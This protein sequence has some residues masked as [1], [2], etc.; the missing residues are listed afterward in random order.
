MMS[1]FWH[2][3][4][5]KQ[6]LLH[7]YLRDKTTIKNIFFKYFVLLSTSKI[8]FRKGAFPKISIINIHNLFISIFRLSSSN[9]GKNLFVLPPQIIDFVP[10]PRAQDLGYLV[11]DA[12]R[13]PRTRASSCAKCAAAFPL[14]ALAP[15]FFI[16][17]LIKI[18]SPPSGRR[19][20]N[21]AAPGHAPLLHIHYS[22]QSSKNSRCE[23]NTMHRNRV[24]TGTRQQD[25]SPFRS[26]P[27][28]ASSTT[29]HRP[30]RP[31]PSLFLSPLRGRR[32]L[33]NDVAASAVRL[34]SGAVSRFFGMFRQRC[35]ETL[36]V[37]NDDG[38]SEIG[39]SE[40]WSP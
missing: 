6:L 3:F 7:K 8:L 32:F 22:T 20:K 16:P 34:W 17:P 24:A 13:G 9:A 38:N 12:S 27:P 31:R 37:P 33:V 21:F 30:L 36:R 10:A 26:S 23:F 28:P 18:L 5:K 14:F 19:Y 15:S 35:R 11:D 39:N 29:T 40:T 2:H 25:L 4:L 1:S